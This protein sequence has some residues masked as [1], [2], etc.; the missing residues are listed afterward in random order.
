MSTLEY[1]QVW[2]GTHESGLRY[3]IAHWGAGNPHLN[4]GYGTWNFYVY[5]REDQTDRFH[6]IWLEDKIKQWSEGGRKY[7]THD[8]NECPIASADWHCGITFYEKGNVEVGMEGQRYIKAGCDYSH[9]WDQGMHGSYSL[10]HVNREAEQCCASLAEIL[11]IK[12]KENA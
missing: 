1:R 11:N 7:L 3:E 4:D 2:T 8:Y 12:P 9:L 5:V 6:E 10:E